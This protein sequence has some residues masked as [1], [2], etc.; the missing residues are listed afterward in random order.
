MKG[1]VFK[2]SR[3]MSEHCQAMASRER[4]DALAAWNSCWQYHDRFPHAAH[5]NTPH[6]HEIDALLTRQESFDII[7]CP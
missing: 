6:Q 3:S 1:N 4:T 7:G 2:G 5:K